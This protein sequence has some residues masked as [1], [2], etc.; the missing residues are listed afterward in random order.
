MFSKRN[1]RQIA[2]VQ[3]ADQIPKPSSLPEIA[4]AGRS[5]VGKSS[6]FNSITGTGKAKVSDKPGMT[7]TL[8][9]FA[10]G[11]Y[12]ILVDLPGIS[13]HFKV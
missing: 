12:L 13:F 11:K 3:S 2:A 1:I 6:L 4:F 5:N 10:V 9:F 8:N 7:Q